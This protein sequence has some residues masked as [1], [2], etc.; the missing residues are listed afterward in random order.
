[1]A[2]VE[3]VKSASDINAPIR[4]KITEVNESLEEKPSAINKLPEDDSQGGAW[5]A[6]VEL[7]EESAKQFDGLMDGDAYKKFCDDE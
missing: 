3:S 6:R 7:D 2:A 1:M 5:I 4:C